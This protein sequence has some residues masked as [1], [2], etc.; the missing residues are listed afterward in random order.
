MSGF[1]KKEFRSKTA[2]TKCGYCQIQIKSENLEIHCNKVHKKPRLAA[3]QRT[4]ENVFKVPSNSPSSS[5]VSAD[6]DPPFIQPD[7]ASAAKKDLG[8]AMEDS[9]IGPPAAKVQKLGNNEKT[10]VDYYDGGGE[11]LTQEDKDQEDNMQFATSFVY[12]PDWCT[13]DR[14]HFGF[15]FRL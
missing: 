8:L 2:L 10:K 15:R 7:P 14:E 11:V 13:K 4:L 5:K 3:G 9:E 6:T 12:N 1:V